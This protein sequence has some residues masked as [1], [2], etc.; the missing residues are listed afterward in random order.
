MKTVW[1]VGLQEGLQY[2]LVRN[3]RESRLPQM[4]LVHE[5]VKDIG[6]EHNGLRYHHL[7]IVKLMKLI[8]LLNDIIQESKAASFSAQ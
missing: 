8:M 4:V 1:Q 5:L 2:L 7:N 3:I 6:T